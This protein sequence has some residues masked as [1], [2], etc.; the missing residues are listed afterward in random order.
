[1]GSRNFFKGTKFGRKEKGNGF[2][3]DLGRGAKMIE[4]LCMSSQRTNTNLKISYDSIHTLEH[5]C[6]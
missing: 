1:M 6:D 2:G 3:T 5:Y 4:L